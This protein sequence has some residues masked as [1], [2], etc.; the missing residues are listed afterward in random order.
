LLPASIAGG[1]I[2]KSPRVYIPL[3]AYAAPHKEVVKK[4]S[5]MD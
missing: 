2:C 4:E 1:S 5:G 3:L